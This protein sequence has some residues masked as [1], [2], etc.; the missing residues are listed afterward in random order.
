MDTPDPIRDL[1]LLGL[2]RHPLQREVELH[3]THPTR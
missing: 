1:L 3:N 2:P